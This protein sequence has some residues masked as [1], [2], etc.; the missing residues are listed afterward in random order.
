[1][2]LLI[3][4]SENKMPV[5]GSGLK[6]Q[7]IPSYPF[8]VG[9]SYSTYK[10]TQR[11]EKFLTVCWIFPVVNFFFFLIIISRLWWK[12]SYFAERAGLFFQSVSTAC[13]WWHPLLIKQQM[14]TNK[15]H[16]KLISTAFLISTLHTYLILTHLGLKE[17]GIQRLNAITRECH[18]T[19][20]VA[21]GL[22]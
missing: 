2:N 21:C 5:W 8:S 11:V 12:K 15:K 10:N 6:K 3:N 1:M 4:K 20:A 13:E 9:S 7:L 14:Q 18:G 22:L 17:A 16:W 19:R